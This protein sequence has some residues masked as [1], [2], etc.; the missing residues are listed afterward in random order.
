MAAVLC[1]FQ[2]SAG[3][4]PSG[5]GEGGA[6]VCFLGATGEPAGKLSAGSVTCSV[7]PQRG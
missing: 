6:A 2:G 7:G 4:E 3:A 1:V 5:E